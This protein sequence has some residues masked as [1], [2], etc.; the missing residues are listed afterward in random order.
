MKVGDRLM[1]KTADF[2]SANLCS[3]QSPRAEVVGKHEATDASVGLGAMVLPISPGPRY[4]QQ[5][6][7]SPCRK[8]S[9]PT[10][11][12]DELGGVHPCCELMWTEEGGC[13]GCRVSEKERRRRHG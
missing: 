8:C 2:E 6:L 1:G 9:G 13:V 5:P 4:L 7:P 12:A 11:L 10:W 3:S